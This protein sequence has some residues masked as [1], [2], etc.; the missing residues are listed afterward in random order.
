MRG[1]DFHGTMVGVRDAFHVLADTPCALVGGGS[2]IAEFERALMIISR[3]RLLSVPAQR[4]RELLAML[5]SSIVRKDLDFL[6]GGPAYWARRVQGLVRRAGLLS[7]SVFSNR[8]FFTFSILCGVCLLQGTTR[9]TGST[10][11]LSQMG[12]THFMGM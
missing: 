12:R 1:G 11:I 2:A 7:G 6:E 5:P 4:Y 10:R 3:R 9:R 8:H